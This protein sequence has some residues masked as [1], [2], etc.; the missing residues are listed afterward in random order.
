M[1]FIK[2]SGK[3]NDAIWGTVVVLFA[4]Y[5]C[6]YLLWSYVGPSILTIFGVGFSK[7]SDETLSWDEMEKE[8]AISEKDIKLF[9]DQSSL[10]D[11]VKRMGYVPSIP[12]VVPV[13]K[14]KDALRQW[15]K[16]SIEGEAR[17]Q[18]EGYEKS[19]IH[20]LALNTELI[21]CIEV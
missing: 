12:W 8:I 14:E 1:I 7:S 4:M 19:E 9:E 16:L 17:E 11:N 10:Q 2:R 21:Q 6:G 13:F 20:G 3:P 18:F 5:T 15:M